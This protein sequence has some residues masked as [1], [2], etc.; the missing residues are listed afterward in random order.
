MQLQDNGSRNVSSELECDFEIRQWY[1]KNISEEKIKFVKF[2]ICLVG[3]NRTVKSN[4]SL[5]KMT[6]SILKVR[7][8]GSYP[9]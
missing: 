8:V 1:E 9:N 6:I 2:D 5:R 3:E 7:K 4:I